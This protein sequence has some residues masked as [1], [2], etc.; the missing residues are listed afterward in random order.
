M[1]VVACVV[2]AWRDGTGIGL[3]RA[4]P[5]AGSVCQTLSWVAR[6]QWIERPE[7]WSSQAKAGLFV[8]QSMG[9][10]ALTYPRPR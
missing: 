5:D 2:S 9:I 1:P 4:T 3:G 6:A 8:T 10:V 7:P